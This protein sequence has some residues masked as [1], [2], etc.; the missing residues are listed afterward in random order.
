MR[1]EFR[2]L[3]AG[4]AV[5]VEFEFRPEQGRVRIDK[6]S[7]IAFEQFRGREFAVPFSQLRFVIEQLQVAWSPSHEQ[8]DHALSFRSEVRLP[9]CEWVRAGCCRSPTVL[10]K[11]LAECNRAK[12]D[13]ALFEKPAARDQ[14]RIAAIKM[15]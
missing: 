12:P 2:K 10:A 6:G 8:E 4:F 3:S 11:E 5:F 1:K 15:C 13:A 14:L 9:G 7:A